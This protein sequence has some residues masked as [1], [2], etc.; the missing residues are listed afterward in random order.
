MTEC[1]KHLN[2][3][4]NLDEFRSL[5]LVLMVRLNGQV[6]QTWLPSSYLLCI[7]TSFWVLRAP[8]SRYSTFFVHF[9]SFLVI[10][11]LKSLKR[12]KMNKKK[13]FCLLLKF[14]RHAKAGRLPDGVRIPT[15]CF[16]HMRTN[17]LT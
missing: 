17:P 1:V 8:K 16:A 12:L 6:L 9:K 11:R 3:K 15:V 10:S 14:G 13:W 2:L 4:W 5:R 7:S